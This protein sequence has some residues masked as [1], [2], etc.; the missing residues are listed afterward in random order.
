MEKVYIT[1]VGWVLLKGRTLKEMYAY[2]YK[3]VLKADCSD[4]TGITLPEFSW[5][6]FN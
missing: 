6:N 2:A 3:E 1:G 4:P 5:Y